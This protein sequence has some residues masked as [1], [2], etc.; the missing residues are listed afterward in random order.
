MKD[1][2]ARR[3]SRLHTILFRAT[4]GRIGR[5]LVNNDMLLLTTHRRSSGRSHTVPLLYLREGDAFV[6]FASW[7]GRRYHPDWYHNLRAEPE[8]TVDVRG[9]NY[10]V[11]AR[12]AEGPERTKWWE[13]ATNAYNGYA[14]YQRRTN[15]QI[16]IVILDS[17]DV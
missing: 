7:G 8:A 9:V 2:T 12:V 5:R 3:L 11:V 6:V 13:R 16:P 4:R 1:T 10:G 17:A 15:R 14:D